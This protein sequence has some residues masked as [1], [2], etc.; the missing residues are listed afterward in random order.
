MLPGANARLAK[1]P[2]VTAPRAAMSP[3]FGGSL[4]MNSAA[5]PHSLATFPNESSGLGASTCIRARRDVVRIFKRSAPYQHRRYTCNQGARGPS[6]PQR[7]GGVSQNRWRESDN[8]MSRESTE[9][10][11]Q[12]TNRRVLCCTH[13]SFS[14]LNLESGSSLR[15]SLTHFSQGRILCSSLHCDEPYP[16]CRFTIPYPS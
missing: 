12:T 4:A 13:F 15:V 8:A 1:A 10:E 7:T 3:S 11:E 14:D 9:E 5:G 2:A 16:P 6:R